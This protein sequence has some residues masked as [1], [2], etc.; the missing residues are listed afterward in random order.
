MDQYGHS[1]RFPLKQ[2]LPSERKSRLNSISKNSTEPSALWIFNINCLYICSFLFDQRHCWEII[3][4]CSVFGLKVIWRFQGNHSFYCQLIMHLHLCTVH[5]D[6]MVLCLFM[7]ILRNTS[8]DAWQRQQGG[9]EAANEDQTEVHT[10]AQYIACG[11]KSI[12]NP[13]RLISPSYT[14][15]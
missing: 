1:C 13:V 5:T 4:C 3:N 2:L 7:W 11:L 10:S 6:Q 12:I 8:W 15:N 14:W 9:G